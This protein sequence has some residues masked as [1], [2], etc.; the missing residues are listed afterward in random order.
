MHLKKSLL[1]FTQ[2]FSLSVGAVG[3]SAS[4]EEN[5]SEEASAITIAPKK[6]YDRVW[7]IIKSDFVDQHYNHQDWEIWRHR[8]DEYLETKEDSN[9]AIETMIA[10][11]GDR[12]TRFLDKKAFDEEKE[13]IEAELT[14]VGIQIG[15]DKT[16]RVV[17]IAPIEGTPGA[18]ADLRPNDIILEIDGKNT[19][20]LSIEEAA[21]M[22]RGPVNTQVTLTVKREKE[23]FKKTITRAVIPIKAIPDGQAKMLFDDIAYIRL[24]TFISKDTVE[25]LI[26]AI[27]KLKDAKGYIIDLRNNPGGLLNNAMIISDMFLSDGVIVSTVSKNGYINSYT[28]RSVDGVS[29]DKPVILLV[30]S[31]SASASEIFSGALRDNGRAEIVGTK[32]FGKGLV[33]AINKL[34]D[35]SGVNVT[36][37]KYLTP[38]KTDINQKGIDPDYE[39]KLEKLDYDLSRGP[40]FF[41]P[42]VEFGKRVPEDGQDKQLMKAVEVLKD[43]FKDPN[44]ISQELKDKIAKLDEEY[45]V[46]LEEQKKKGETSEETPDMDIQ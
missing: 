31:N 36:I 15:L 19:S 41:D 39:V 10:S 5:N 35:G 34:G 44:P 43:K 27:E 21:K 7:K 38:N 22:I 24:S 20:G 11:L 14:G 18:L 1:I 23:K 46:K 17:V 13:S 45:K 37:A 42:N 9:K 25:E 8:Y 30:N 26:E 4:L 33:Q 2:I 28:A 32:T 12:Y 29:K 40:W 3:V 6:L 16:G